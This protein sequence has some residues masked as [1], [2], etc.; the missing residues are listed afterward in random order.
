MKCKKDFYWFFVL[1]FTN[2]SFVANAQNS[3]VVLKN[4]WQFRQEKTAKWNVATVP[5]EVHTD[6][7][8][9]KLIPDPFYRDNEKKLQWI[10]KK[11][12][13]YKTSFQVT[14]ATL[15]KKNATLVFDGLDTYATVYLNK[16]L[17]LKA[18]NMFRQWRVD[19]KKIIK[20][21]NNDLVVVFQSAQNVVDSLAKKDLPF[22]IPDN[23]RAYVRKAQYHF[24]WDWGPKFT[25]CGIWKAVR[26]EAYDEKT[27]EKP[28]V[29]NRKIELVQQPDSLGKSF[30][31][32][33][34]GKPVYMKGANYI[35]SDAFLSR[36][37]KKEYEKVILMA[38]D[39]NMNMLRVWGGGIYEDDY[40]Y[41]LCDKYGINVW[42]DFMFAG[43][44]VPGDKAF[45]DN[46]KEEVQYQVKRLRHH[47][48]IVL[49]CGN[50][51]SDE[52]FKNWGWQKS[53][54][55]SKQDS[56]RL[57]KDYVRLFQDSIPKWVKEVDDK[58]PYIS[59]SPLFG[60]GKE[61][62]IK[63]GDSH[64][65]GT[66]W[67]LEDIEVVQNKTGRFISE[68]GMQAM[69]N[70]SSIEKFTSPEDRYLFSDVLKAHQKAGKGFTKLNSYLNRYFIDSTKVKNMKVEDY[71]Y[72]TQC[73]QY[74]SLKNIIGIHRSKAPYN[75]GTLVWQLNDCWPVASWS[76]TDYYNRQPKAAWYAMREAYRDDKTPEIDL[77]RP[78]DLKLENPKITWTIKG[79]EIIIKALKSAKY[80]YVEIKGYK[81]KLS[82]NYM[83]LDAGEER[84]ISFEG[85]IIKPIITVTSLY[86][87]LNRY[88]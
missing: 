82:T 75:M 76:V 63:E 42:Q 3:S 65:W 23:P 49:W 40:F 86:D 5:G 21:G 6:L 88:K 15:N 14:P 30:Y 18:D 33:I 4:G 79:N 87:V 10:E 61:K 74:Y 38:K 66:W 20:S 64:Y 12:W 28:Y 34:D 8:N 51:E 50:N 22:V 77:T 67:G 1:Y 78:I 83:D 58:R 56:T 73:L 13:E 45:L 70:Y 46:V 53:M 2:L 72:L 55:M 60:W 47:P 41:D 85:K 62:S 9:N 71:T 52:A 39:A 59:S 43:T 84:I 81:G 24:G 25:T 7:L 16:Q 26:L 11:N 57:W 37:T 17:V 27:L 48:S 54:N 80:V 36:V 35:P 44:M 29:L 32:K 69:P 19:V 68:Y 31:F